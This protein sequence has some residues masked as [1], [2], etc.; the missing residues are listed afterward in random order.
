MAAFAADL[1]AWLELR[2]IAARPDSLGYRVGRFVRRHRAI[3]GVT[4]LGLGAVT[5][6]LVV[7]LWQAQVARA[8]AGRAEAAAAAARRQTARAETGERAAQRV[9]E[10]LQT[11]LAEAN[12]TLRDSTREP[13]VDDAVAAA[14]KRVDAELADDPEL[15]FAVLGV[16]GVVALGNADDATAAGYLERAFELQQRLP[17][18]TPTA[19]ADA[20]QRLA[21]LRL[22]RKDLAGAHYLALDGLAILA[23]ALA[24]DAAG[25]PRVAAEL[26]TVVR[27]IRFYQTE[28]DLALAENAKVV[29]L[30]RRMLGDTAFAVGMDLYSGAVML[31]SAKRH[32]EAEVLYRQSLAI[33]EARLAPDDF[34]IA[35]VLGR[36]ATVRRDQGH[37]RDALEMIT[38]AIAVLRSHPEQPENLAASLKDLGDTHGQLGQ[39]AESRAALEEAL[40]IYQT[41]DPRVWRMELGVEVALGDIARNEGRFADAAVHHDRA[42]AAARAAWGPDHVA[43]I[44]TRITAIYERGLA[45]DP[46]AAYAEI[47]AL[48]PSIPDAKNSDATVVARVRNF[49]GRIAIEARLGAAAVTLMREA[50]ALGEAAHTPTSP[51]L[52]RIRIGLAL[53][54]VALGDPAALPEARTLLT[55]NLAT[56]D[57]KGFGW[58]LTAKQARAAL[59]ALPR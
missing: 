55:D 40:A 7:A 25:A 32:A 42:S 26:H 28:L 52:A 15:Q 1:R 49:R 56:L 9:T 8:N 30:R 41:R 45:G 14:A 34:R 36:L 20:Y 53:A 10:F 4:A 22:A 2:P 19:R 57:A 3:V 12:D 23:P 29:A 58:D 59:D 18:L 31:E 13:T 39:L 38:R 35:V 37:G 5:A 46:A 17:G 24:A 44:N 51:V 11:I 16:L 33:H 43:T 21:N 54:L 48:E 50:V 6:A 27:T 47:T